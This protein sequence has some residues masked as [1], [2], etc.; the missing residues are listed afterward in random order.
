MANS[1]PGEVDKET[2]DK[3]LQTLDPRERDVIRVR[4]GL[5]DGE[6]HTLEDTGKIVKLTKERVRQIEAAAFRK[7]RQPFRARILKEALA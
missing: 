2:L 5:D 3:V 4:Y 1:E 6:Y 7:L